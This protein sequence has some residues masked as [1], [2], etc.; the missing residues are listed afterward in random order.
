MDKFESLCKQVSLQNLRLAVQQNI[1][2]FRQFTVLA[3]QI[4]NA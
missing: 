2:S 3:K 1:I 4:I